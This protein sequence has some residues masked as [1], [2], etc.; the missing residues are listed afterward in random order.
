MDKKFKFL[1]ANHIV[2]LSLSILMIIFC[3]SNFITGSES[4]S[5]ISFITPPNGDLIASTISISMV[6][7]IT[8]LV[9]L[10]VIAFCLLISDFDVIEDNKILNMLVALQV[11]LSA[12]LVVLS[13]VILICIKLKTSQLNRGQLGQNMIGIGSV[14][15]F[16]FSLVV[17]VLS[18]ALKFVDEINF[19]KFN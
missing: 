17:L 11:I 4:M 19:D 12:I 9:V 18:L 13:F 10:V 15:I 1:L 16:V 2:C 6:L 7:L 3:A 8:I 5:G 14:I